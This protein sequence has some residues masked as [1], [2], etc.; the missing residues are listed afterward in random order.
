MIPISTFFFS[1]LL[2]IV[3][4]NLLVLLLMCFVSGQSDGAK[5]ERIDDA[6]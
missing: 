3:M 2:V 4:Y 1:L 6:E 5:C